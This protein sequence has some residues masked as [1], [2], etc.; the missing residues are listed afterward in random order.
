MEAEVATE[1]NDKDQA[2]ETEASENTE[3][4]DK[5]RVNETKISFFHIP[6]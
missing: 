3:D 4:L 5:Y 2:I 6:T 1:D